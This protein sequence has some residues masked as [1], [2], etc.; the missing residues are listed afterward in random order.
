MP[1]RPACCS[2]DDRCACCTPLLAA[3]LGSCVPCLASRSTPVHGIRCMDTTASS[4]QAAALRIERP[5]QFGLRAAKVL[6]QMRPCHPLKCAVLHRSAFLPV[7]SELHKVRN[8]AWEAAAM[9]AV[10]RRCRWRRQ[11][12]GIMSSAQIATEWPNWGPEGSKWPVPCS[13]LGRVKE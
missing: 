3:V 9:A 4:T 7:K 11:W 12:S 6:H 5:L 13:R 1:A 2:L 10:A 8:T